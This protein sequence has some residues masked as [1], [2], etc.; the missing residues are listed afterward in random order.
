MEIE[1]LMPTPMYSDSSFDPSVTQ[2]VVTLVFH[3]FEGV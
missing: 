1:R 3:R 2:L